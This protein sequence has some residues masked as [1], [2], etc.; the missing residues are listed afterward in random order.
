MHFPQGSIPESL[1]EKNIR[2]DKL[3][4]P[5]PLLK[6]ATQI[7]YKNEMLSRNVE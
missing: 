3:I 7:E 2:I 1:V 4:Q 6:V 5:F